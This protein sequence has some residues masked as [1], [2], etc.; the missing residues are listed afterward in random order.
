MVLVGL[1]EKSQI[2]R[3]LLSNP[4][5]NI[6][7][8]GDLDPFFWPYTT[9]YGWKTQTGLKA[10]VLK[11]SGMNPP[12]ILAF[13]DNIPQM[14]PLLK[15]LQSQ[16]PDQFY[17]HLSPGL[18]ESF[19]ENFQISPHGKHYKMALLD[20][21]K[22]FNV[23]CSDVFRLS[24][25]Q[26]DQIK[27]LYQESYPENWFDARMLETNQYFGII[28][29]NQIVSIAGI[30]VYSPEYKVAALG[31]I[32]TH[33]ACRSNGHG[34]KVTARLCQSLLTEDIQIGLNVKA[35]NVAAISCYEKV[36]FRKVATY[37]EYK[38]EKKTHS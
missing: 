14:I 22:V 29:N 2:E 5:V 21:E 36:G 16:L 15:N 3:F 31:N 24:E 12:T 13:T 11:Y 37:F 28:R 4:L 7:S 30:H 26:V 20:K 25:D 10:I 18:D 38:M 1:R 9:W 17:A 34:K 27:G 8:L 19:L 35:D 23:E 6:Y 33:P 32:T